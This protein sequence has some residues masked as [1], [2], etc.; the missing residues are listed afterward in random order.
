MPVGLLFITICF[1]DNPIVQ[2]NFTADPAPMVYN[3]TFYMYTGHDEDGSTVWFNMKEWRCYSTTDMA[4]WTDRGSPMN[5][6]QF[7]WT[8]ADA[9]AGQCVYRNGKFYYN[10]MASVPARPSRSEGRA[11]GGCDVNPCINDAV[12]F[13]INC[14][15]LS[16]EL[17]ALHFTFFFF[18]SYKPQ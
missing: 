5:L 15:E 7:T 2:T 6:T 18:T 4:N 9:W 11:G 8:N 3:D 17:I 10:E 16:G 12:Y 1:A 13:F 14:G